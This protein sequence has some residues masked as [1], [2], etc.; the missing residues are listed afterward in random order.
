M[1]G[2]KRKNPAA[3]A[4]GRLGGKKRAAALSAE[5]LSAQGKKA[6]ASRWAKSKSLEAPLEIQ[7]PEKSEPA[8]PVHKFRRSWCPWKRS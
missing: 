6:A 7:R 3:I 2:E 1:A 4:L 5:D 8:K